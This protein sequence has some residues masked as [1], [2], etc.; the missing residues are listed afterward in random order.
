MSS[1]ENASI[2][3]RYFE[4]INNKDIAALLELCDANVVEHPAPHGFPPGIEGIRL[5]KE[6][7][8]AALPDAHVVVDDVFS[9]GNKVA[10]RFTLHATNIQTGKAYTLHAIGIGYIANGRFTEMWQGTIDETEG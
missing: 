8:L 10:L 1:E 6:R 5:H 2:V 7:A 3:Y 4:A 9:E